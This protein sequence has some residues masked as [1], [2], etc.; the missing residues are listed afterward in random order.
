MA[1]RKTITVSITPEQEAFVRGR[2][3]SGRFGSVSEVV[4]AGLRLLERDEAIAGA[5]MAGPAI[6]PSGHTGSE[7][8]SPT[9]AQPDA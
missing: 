9:Q 5:A 2:L 1:I 4:R 3:K 6:V 8:S 7:T